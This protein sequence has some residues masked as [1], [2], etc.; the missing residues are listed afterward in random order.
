MK[1][2]FQITLWMNVR[3][4]EYEHVSDDDFII[5]DWTFLKRNNRFFCNEASME[6]KYLRISCDPHIHFDEILQDAPDYDIRSSV[7]RMD[8]VIREIFPKSMMHPNDTI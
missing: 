2:P 8:L 4:R 1:I 6:I 3:R 5:L 7:A